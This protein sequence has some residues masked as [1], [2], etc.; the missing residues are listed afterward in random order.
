MYAA[1]GEHRLKAPCQAV[2]ELAATRPRAFVTDAEVLQEIL[3]RYLA[4]R[5]WPDG[6]ALFEGFERLM[7]GRIEPLRASD[8]VDAAATADAFDA[9]S[10]R[11]LVHLAVMRRIDVTHVVSAD[12][13]F[14][15]VAGVVRLDP[16]DLESITAAVAS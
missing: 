7:R 6:R 1:G 8:V 14:A 15:H 13:A 11:D 5:R 2:L 9:M 10:A 12:R 16:N 4:Q 3:H